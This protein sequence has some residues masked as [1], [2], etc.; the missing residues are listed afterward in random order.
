MSSNSLIASLKISSRRSHSSLGS[1]SGFTSSRTIST[2]LRPQPAA[3]R[4][5]SRSLFRSAK[6]M[7][8][9]SARSCL[10]SSDSSW[11]IWSSLAANS[12]SS[13]GSSSSPLNASL[14]LRS[15]SMSSEIAW[16]RPSNSSSMLV[17]SFASSSNKLLIL[18]R[19]ETTSSS[20]SPPRFFLGFFFF[21]LRRLE[22]G[23]T[24]GR[25]MGSSR[26][27]FFF[28]HCTVFGTPRVCKHSPVARDHFLTVKSSDPLK[29]YTSSESTQKTES[30]CPEK[31]R[32]SSPVRAF[33]ALQVVSKEPVYITP[34]QTFRQDTAWVCPRMVS[35]ISAVSVSQVRTD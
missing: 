7:A 28:A 12:S 11:S 9:R 6:K 34:S 3:L 16:E 14:C 21:F 17:Y 1:S 4:I 29:R 27:R 20:S 10:Y 22:T 19:A 35:C 25:D 31:V 26:R 32:S 13:S 5:S 24:S 18:S 2:A 33:Q 23:A 15:R 30:S 8:V